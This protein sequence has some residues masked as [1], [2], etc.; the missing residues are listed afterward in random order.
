MQT[1]NEGGIHPIYEC[2]L[3]GKQHTTV[4]GK[5]YV[6]SLSRSA[7]QIVL[8]RRHASELKR[9]VLDGFKA[10]IGTAVHEAIEKSLRAKN[11]E[12]GWEKYLLESPSQMEFGSYTLSGRLDCMECVDREANTWRLIDHKTRS[13]WSWVYYDDVAE[14]EYCVQLS[15][16]KMMQE[17][18]YGRKILPT[19]LIGFIMG[20]WKAPENTDGKY[21]ALPIMTKEILLMS[22]DEIEQYIRK[23]LDEIAQT[24]TKTDEELKP[25]SPAQLWQKDAWAVVHP[26]KSRALKIHNNEKDATEHAEV[27]GPPHRVEYRQGMAK[28]CNYCQ[29]ATVCSQ[30][31][32]LKEKGL[33]G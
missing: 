20:D 19:G 28:A 33:V 32:G 22:N 31:R 4:P 1:T 29:C 25:C 15:A 21:P 8:E 3:N 24:D 30:F 5:F 13:Q 9:D 6:S 14:H 26:N 2:W 17:K 12:L 10:A 7:R 16:Y 11:V 23:W 27:L 18:I